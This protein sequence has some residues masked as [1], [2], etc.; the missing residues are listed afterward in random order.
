MKYLNKRLIS[1]IILFLTLFFL[2]K[3]INFS[4]RPSVRYSGLHCQLDQIY[5]IKN[6]NPDII[7]FGSSRTLSGINPYVIE[8]EINKNKDQEINVFNIARSWRGNG[9]I[10]QLIKD[11]Y[12]NDQQI[13]KAVV[14]ELSN[15]MF[16]KR[17]SSKKFYFENSLYY[18][19]YYPKFYE[20]ATFETLIF[21]IKSKRH[22][23]VIFNLRDFFELNYFK[24]KNLLT[25]KNKLKIINN[26][27]YKK[28][29]KNDKKICYSEKS[30]IKFNKKKIKQRDRVIKIVKN[31]NHKDNWK[32]KDLYFDINNVNH[33]R[34]NFYLNEIIKLLENKKIK[35]YFMIMPKLNFG[36]PSE[37]LIKNLKSKFP[38]V[39]IIYGDKFIY[40]KIYIKEGW[41]DKTHMI[42][43]SRDKWSKWVANQLVK[44]F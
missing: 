5:N 24:I 16:T 38:T 32:Q 20:N 2:I 22:Q 39:E 31:E 42:K 17:T 41:R 44:I 6:K 23:N 18:Q 4:D 13:N 8:N 30:E 26:T 37:K 9:Q 3:L 28:R 10:Y 36:L 15:F 40:E 43:Y 25:M 14:I 19:G 21:D 27:N 34:P 33:I 29:R 7:F 1:V 35:V 12:S 11:F